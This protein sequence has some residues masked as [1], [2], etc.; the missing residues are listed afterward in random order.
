[1]L[2]RKINGELIHNRIVIWNLEDSRLLFKNGFYGK[3]LGISKPKDLTFEVP[4]IL[5]L[6]ETYYLSK[7]KKLNIYKEKIAN[8][9]SSRKILDICK[10]QYIDFK[11][12]FLVYSNLREKKLIVCPGIKFGCDFAVYKHGPGIDHA[13]YLIEVKKE[14]DKITA[15]EVVLSG[16]LATTVKKQFTL[17]IPD[18]KSKDVKFISFDWWRA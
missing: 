16:R 5:D 9:I 17:A 4:L 6:I 13:P 15:T 14:E 11:E 18:L 12:K 10:E 8:K 3:P 7:K 1:M 2:D